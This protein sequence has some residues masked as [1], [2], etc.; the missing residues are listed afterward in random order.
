MPSSSMRQLFD[1][2]HSTWLSSDVWPP[3]SWSTYQH[4]ARTN[5]DVEGWYHRLNSRA[6]CSHLTLY[7]LI[8]L[9]WEKAQVCNVHD[10]KLVYGRKLSR[11]QKSIRIFMLVCTSYGQI[12]ILVVSQQDDCSLHT[13]S[14]TD[15]LNNTGT[16]IEW[17]I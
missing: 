15:H 10:V 3:S 13:L 16:G 5:N 11:R 17:L 2:V 9:L 14:L 1:Y 7:V 12:L 6:R 4:P 8:R